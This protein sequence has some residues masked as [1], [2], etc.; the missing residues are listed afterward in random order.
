MRRLTMR[1]KIILMNKSYYRVKHVANY[2]ITKHKLIIVIEAWKQEPVKGKL[3]G[4]NT[5]IFINLRLQV[6]S[7]PNKI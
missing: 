6:V 3:G 1:N 2:Y 4:R 7:I 5:L